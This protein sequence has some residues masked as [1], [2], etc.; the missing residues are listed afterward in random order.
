VEQVRENMKSI[1]AVEKITPDVITRIE[2]ILGNW[3]R[4]MN[5]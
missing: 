2:E 5:G 3:K 1:D 4:N